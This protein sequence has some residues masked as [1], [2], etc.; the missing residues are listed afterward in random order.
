MT[1]RALTKKKKNFIVQTVKSI[2]EKMTQDAK[3]CPNFYFKDLI[4]GTKYNQCY[5]NSILKKWQRKLDKINTGTAN[6][7]KKKAK[8][9]SKE[10]NSFHSFVKTRSRN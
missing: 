9:Y 3:L 2:F 8:Q 7:N 5:K 10:L 4:G 6:G 1:C